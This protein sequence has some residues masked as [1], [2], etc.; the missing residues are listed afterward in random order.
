M[1]NEPSSY[2]HDE[3]Q[4]GYNFFLLKINKK[5][6]IWRAEKKANKSHKYN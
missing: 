4:Y 5:K 3:V 1:K 2:S 6:N